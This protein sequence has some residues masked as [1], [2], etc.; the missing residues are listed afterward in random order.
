MEVD[1]AT[2][3]TGDAP[4]AA[5][6]V[7]TAT[8]ASGARARKARGSLWTDGHSR[9]LTAGV[10]AAR[11]AGGACV[12]VVLAD[13]SAVEVEVKHSKESI[14]ALVEANEKIRLAAA[15]AEGRRQ[16]RWIE[17]VEAAAP[18]GSP[19]P[20]PER[21][22]KSMRKRAAR[23]AKIEKQAAQLRLLEE[24]KA[25]A[26][27]QREER[28]SQ[29]ASAAATSAKARIVARRAVLE[30]GGEPLPVAVLAGTAGA[31]YSDEEFGDKL[32]KALDGLPAERLSTALETLLRDDLMRSDEFDLFD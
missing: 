18:S 2:T 30:Q 32:R 29:L 11:S 25:A 22:T 8:A 14:P 31:A 24:A 5:E 28:I 15:A 27:D 23:R 9:A 20:P 10:L 4:A 13:G 16:Q 3:P 7:H 19:A 26:D 12:R 6:A 17:Q 1:R 21:P